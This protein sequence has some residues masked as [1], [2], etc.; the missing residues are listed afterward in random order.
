[1]GYTF[2]FQGMSTRGRPKPDF[3]VSAVTETRAESA[4][5]V[6]AET[7]TGAEAWA[8]EPYRLLAVAVCA[9]DTISHAIERAYAVA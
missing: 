6:S 4:V 7:E 9:Y 2:K 5:S 1:M 8:A 3:S